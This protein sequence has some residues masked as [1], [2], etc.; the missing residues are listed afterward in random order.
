MRKSLAVGCLLSLVCLHP[1][2]GSAAERSIEKTRYS[3]TALGKSKHTLSREIQYQDEASD[4]E[5]LFQA[6]DE[7]A[8]NEDRLMV[9]N[10]PSAGAAQK[11]A[12]AQTSPMLNSRF[13][14]GGN[15]TWVSIHPHEHTSFEG[16]LGGAQA[17]YEYRP[18]NRFYGAAKLAWRQGETH[19]PA[20]ER[21]LLYIDA[22]ERLG[23]T[24]S[25]YNDDLLL[26][27]FSGL[28]YRHL[29]QKLDPK[30]GDSIKFR[31]NEIYIP[32]GAIADYAVNN[33]FAI[34]LGF[35][36]MPQVYPT[37]N[38]EPLEGARWI[39]ENELA[40]FYVEMPFT[41]TLTD[42]KR[43]SIIVN[44]F[45]EYWKDGH[46]TAKTKRGVKLGLPGNTYNFGG[47]DVNF[48][49]SF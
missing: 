47:V 11:P 34:G 29:G 48:A 26:T 25:F 7:I 2:F 44:P 41:F 45:Y 15:Y 4:D 22:Q 43:W 18:L 1:V 36:W 35:T 20:G 49:Y 3:A 37:V 8:L 27:L 46:T 40:N 5:A 21:S 12:M 30:H 10:Q 6:D 31:Y 24:F 28:G 33:W 9:Q 38:I 17:I 16:S 19:G 23:Y 39:I 32:V 14:F 13:Q 42:D